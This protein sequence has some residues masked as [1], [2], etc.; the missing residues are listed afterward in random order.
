MSLSWS[1][2]CTPYWILSSIST[3]QWVLATDQT[4]LL[5][6]RVSK[7]NTIGACPSNKVLEVLFDSGSTMT[8]IHCSS[9]PAKCQWILDLPPF[10]FQNLGGK[11]ASN[12]AIKLSDN[13]FSGYN[14]NSLLIHRLLTCLTKTVNTTSSLVPISLKNIT[15]LFTI[16][17]TYYNGWITRYLPRILMISLTLTFSLISMTNYAKI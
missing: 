17:K 13:I 3:V 9:L 11:M 15:S 8:M 10:L 2:S 6:C 5:S 1:Y 12:K 14:S 4:I 7:W 16:M